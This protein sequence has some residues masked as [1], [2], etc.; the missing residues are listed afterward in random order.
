MDP[1]T[2]WQCVATEDIINGFYLVDKHD[3]S[4]HIANPTLKGLAKHFSELKGAL[5]KTP[6]DEA[7]Q[8]LK[9]ILR[10][11]ILEM[12]TGKLGI[13][14]EFEHLEEGFVTQHMK[15]HAAWPTIC[16]VLMAYTKKMKTKPEGTIKALLALCPKQEGDQATKQEG[17]GSGDKGEGKGEKVKGVETPV[18]Q[19]LSVGTEVVTKATKNKEAFDKRVGIIKKVCSKTYRV[20]LKEGPSKGEEKDFQHH[21]VEARSTDE[22]AEKKARK[23]RELFG[24][25][26]EEGQPGS[27]T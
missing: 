14:M 4:E 24:L 12:I 9:K 8:N 20:L 3:V 16:K 21:N 7:K 13:V 27:S 25:P 15:D 18:E 17:E 6:N 5:L 23:A 22:P 11:A 19:K 1:A 26:M 10:S 2:K